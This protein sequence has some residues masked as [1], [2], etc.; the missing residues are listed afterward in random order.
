MIHNAECNYSLEDA[1]RKYKK[2]KEERA[3]LEFE[4]GITKELE[5]GL[6]QLINIMQS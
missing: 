3:Q 4:L 1:A 6:S 2:V 5:R